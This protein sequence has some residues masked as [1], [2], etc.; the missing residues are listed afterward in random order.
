MKPAATGV[1]DRRSIR[2]RACGPSWLEFTAT[3][4]RDDVIF[5]LGEATLADLVTILMG[6]AGGAALTRDGV[7]S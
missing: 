1:G 6:G 3:Q 7:S 5:S 4:F 2:F